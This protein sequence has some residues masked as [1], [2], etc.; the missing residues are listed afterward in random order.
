MKTPCYAR[1]ERGATLIIALVMLSLITVMVSGSFTLSTINL[2]AVGNMQVRHEALASANAALAQ[3]ISSP[4]TDDPAG[5]ASELT[6][7][8]NNDDDDDY[9]VVIG[10]P[11]CVRATQAGSTKLSSTTLV[12][13]SASWNTVW[14]IQAA[15][16]DAATGAQTI[17]H[18]AVR[19]L[20]SDTEK[21]L[22]C[23]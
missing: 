21:N 13:P 17:V 4:F 9:T 22:V 3:I 16:N 6:F 12:L 20:L 23:P 10:V 19:V 2:K 5:A 7:D 18:S 15:V 14:A 8:V 11:Q 1:S